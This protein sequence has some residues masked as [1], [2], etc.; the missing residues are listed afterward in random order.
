[1]SVFLSG[2]DIA[3]LYVQFLDHWCKVQF[4]HSVNLC[5]KDFKWPLTRAWT[6]GKSRCK[7]KSGCNRLPKQLI[8]RAFYYKAKITVQTGVYNGGHN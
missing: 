1:M 5:D 7:A 8:M 4:H 3:W 2:I 6:Q